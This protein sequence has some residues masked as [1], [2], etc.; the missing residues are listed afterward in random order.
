[1]NVLLV[2]EYYFANL[3]LVQLSNELA[4][5]RHSVSVATSFR[6]FERGESHKGVDIFEITPFV[7]I[8][9]IPH[10][11]SFPLL[12]IHNI[13][14]ERDIEITHALMDYST[15]TAVAS[16]VSK[17][18]HTPF[19][20]TIQGVGTRTGR[21]VVDTLAECYDWTI[22]RSIFQN[23]KKL[24]LLSRNL[25]SRT[26][27]LGIEDCKVAVIPSG[28]DC[29]RFDPRRPEV[30]QKATKLRNNFDISRDDFVVGYCG[31]I[32][33]AKGLVYLL[34]AISKVKREFPNV[35]LLVV[36][37]GSQKAEL[38][39]KSRDLQIRTIFAGYQSD[40]P[41]YYAL[42]D[43]FVLPSLFEGLPSVVLEAIAM[44]KAVIATNV[45]G[46]S[47]IVI[48]GQNG[49]LVPPKNSEEVANALISL[50]DDSDLKGKMGKAGR[51]TAQRNFLWDDIVDK[52]EKVY[53][54]VT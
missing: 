5:R 42:M 35:V 48:E 32:T 16:L 7:T 38:Q 3:D 9:S 25:I 4:K 8:Y 24:I 14:K 50:V 15:N 29:T 28:V 45:G 22:E 31:R 27:K 43:A 47:D 6:N 20:C 10:S 1:V 39:K 52:V 44:E 34:D 46:T 23:A 19:I 41:P 11:L 30:R 21:L 18:M 54:E 26:R 33:P 36:G 2:A 37:E 49:F 12:K 17:A 13:I 53:E 40:T 51:E